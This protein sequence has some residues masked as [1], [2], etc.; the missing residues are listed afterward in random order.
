[1]SKVYPN[2]IRTFPTHRDGRDFVLA[3][4]VNELQDELTG[5][6]TAIGIKPQTYT[7]AAGK[8][9][10]YKDI[11]SRLDAMQRY[12]DQVAA[13]V[14]QLVDASNT[15]WNLPV[16]SARCTGTSIA[17]TVDQLDV[18]VTKDWHPVT[19]NRKLTDVGLPAPLT[20]FPWGSSSP[21]I[22]CPKTGWWIIT[23]RL[24]ATIPSGPNSLDHMCY[25]RMYLSDHGTDVATAE[26]TNA[27]G[28]HGYHRADLTYSGEW[29]QGERLQMQLRHMDSMRVH[30]R[31]SYPNPVGNITAWA[32][33]GLTYIR[34]LPGV[35]NTR[36][37]DDID[38]ALP[39]A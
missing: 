37:I 17:P 9:H 39:S 35:M 22:T 38:P 30:K 13:S 26:S 29:Y 14:N 2:A 10:A 23:M 18:D 21:T 12:D 31:A 20:F 6:E 33:C 7:D 19:W 28:T 11:A 5:V 27:R 32:W 36:P 24:I 4:D 3:A 15:G 1:M 25:A 8:A 34:A 16:G